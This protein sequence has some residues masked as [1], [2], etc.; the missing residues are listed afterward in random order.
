MRLCIVRALVLEPAVLLLKLKDRL[1]ILIVSHHSEQDERIA[2]KV[3][4]FGDKDIVS[5]V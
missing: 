2:D 4:E 5:V 3:V 1:T